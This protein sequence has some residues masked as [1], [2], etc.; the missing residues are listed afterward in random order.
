[1]L[2][3][4]GISH[5]GLYTRYQ[6]RRGRLLRTINPFTGQAVDYSTPL[7]GENWLLRVMS[8]GA[9]SCE[10]EPDTL[11]FMDRGSQ[12]RA[13]CDTLTIYSNHFAIADLVVDQ[14][15]EQ[16]D[17]SFEA[18][19]RACTVYNYTP[20]LRTKKQIRSNPVLLR[21]LAYMRQHL[22]LYPVSRE[23]QSTAHSLLNDSLNQSRYCFGLRFHRSFI[24]TQIDTLLFLMHCSGR[25][26]INIDEVPYG[27]NS[28]ITSS[29]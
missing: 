6:R 20:L 2:D 12:L 5:G 15:T 21:N 1:M 11:T 14:Q 27:P 8:P 9:I 28:N 26:S 10:I 23:I 18:L 4:A 17:D 24:Q 7:K 22:I 16:T 13:Y 19:R 29:V 25:L 3:E